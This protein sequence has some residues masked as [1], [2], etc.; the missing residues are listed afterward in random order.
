[1]SSLPFHGQPSSDKKEN[2]ESA[3]SLAGNRVVCL[4]VTEADN[5][6]LIF[7]VTVRV[8]P[9]TQPNARISLPGSVRF[10]SYTETKP[11]TR[12]QRPR[13]VLVV[14]LKSNRS[15]QCGV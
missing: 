9:P 10:D 13:A 15:L 6:S 1:M 3:M 12:K 5:D 7:Y 8:Y 14:Y 4:K 11:S 2:H